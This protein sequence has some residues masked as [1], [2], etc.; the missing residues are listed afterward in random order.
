[1]HCDASTGCASKSMKDIVEKEAILKVGESIP[2]FAF[3]ENGKKFIERRLGNR[4]KAKK[5]VNPLKPLI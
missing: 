1:M 4:K 5:D 3:S 2:I